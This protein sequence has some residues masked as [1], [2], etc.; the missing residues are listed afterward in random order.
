MIRSGQPHAKHHVAC[1]VSS[2]DL[3]SGLSFPDSMTASS[4]NRFVLADV[5]E[6]VRSRDV[7]DAL[8]ISDLDGGGRRLEGTARD[9]A[10]P[11]F[12]RLDVAADGTATISLVTADRWL[13]ESI[14][15][16]L[17]HYGDPIEE[18]VAE[19]LE[20]LEVKAP[21][22]SVIVR[23]F[24]SD[25]LLYTF[26]TPLPSDADAGTAATWLLAYEAA[27]RGLGDMTSDDED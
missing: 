7:F 15:S 22:S 11:A 27:F 25:D 26:E 1:G 9:A 18:L 17:M 20:E 10:E 23:H 19:E 3:S 24:R 14:E 8:A 16:D 5:L 12:Y 6:T 2:V 21:A 13:S 4:S